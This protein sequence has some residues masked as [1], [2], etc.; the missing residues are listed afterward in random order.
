MIFFLNLKKITSPANEF[1]L[2]KCRN[3]N[4]INNFFFQN[5][6]NVQVQLMSLYYI[7]E[8]IVKWKNGLFFSNLKKFTSPANEFLL[9]K[10]RNNRKMK[11]RF[12]FSNLKKFTS[13]AN[14]FLLHKCKNNRK[15]KKRF[16]FSNLKK[17]MKDPN[18]GD[19]AVAGVAALWCGE[20]RRL[21]S[22]R[23]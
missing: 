9:H 6:K 5:W 3:K 14:V 23:L 20:T 18:R 11:K 7:I 16:F 22:V 8:T 19:R 15:M 10:C 4:K 13:P 12:F 21:Y 17:C 2:H 1:L